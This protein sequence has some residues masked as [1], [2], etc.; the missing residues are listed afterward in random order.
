[1]R[2]DRTHWTI[3]GFRRPVVGAIAGLIVLGSVVAGHVQADPADD[4]L[5]KLNELSRQAEQTTEAIA[6]ILCISPAGAA[7]EPRCS[8]HATAV[9]AGWR[10]AAISHT[11]STPMISSVVSEGRLFGLTPSDWSMLLGSSTLCGVLTLLF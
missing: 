9:L 8:L 11:A 2:L 3:R 1:M 6:R 7:F 4:A 5:A 10:Y